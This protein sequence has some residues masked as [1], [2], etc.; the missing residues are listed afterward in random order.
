M[1]A[2]VKVDFHGD[3]LFAQPHDDGAIIVAVKPIIDRL[4]LDWEAQRK[5]IQRDELLSEGAAIMEVPSPGGPQ[6]TTCLPLSLL[7]G[8]LFGISTGSILDPE[9][10]AAVQAYQREC[11]E[12]LYRHFFGPKEDP[13]E[14]L[15]WQAIAAKI[16]L[17]R[18]TRLTMGRK[19]AQA[20]WL[21]LGLPLGEPESAP[22]PRTLALQGVDFVRQ[23]LSERT[24]EDGAGRVQAL[25]LYRDFE[26]WLEQQPHAP[27]M[28]K[29]AFGLCL[30]ALGLRKTT[31]QNIYYLG[32]RLK[33]ITELM[34]G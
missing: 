2:L 23:Y 21:M 28:T 8:F 19:P 32:I 6:K 20:L 31:S 4:G 9:V 18:E 10:K 5:R 1:S 3:T 25:T 16:S 22:A 17:I 26:H 12:V 27:K 14:G 34:G 7:P 11:H 29:T 30:N 13:A 15:D 33:H 24:I